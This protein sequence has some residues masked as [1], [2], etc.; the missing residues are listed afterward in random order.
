MDVKERLHPLQMSRSTEFGSSIG[1]RLGAT[2]P[3]ESLN[4]AN[5]RDPQVQI[6]RLPEE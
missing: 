1:L 4:E 5:R 3:S 2:G 6:R